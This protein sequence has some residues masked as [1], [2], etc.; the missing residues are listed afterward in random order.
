MSGLREKLAGIL[1]QAYLF[2]DLDENETAMF[3][4]R[5]RFEN[6]GDGRTVIAEGEEGQTLFLI[7]SGDVKVTK[8]IE[9]EAEQVIGILRPGDFFGEMALLDRLPRSATVKAMGQV[10]LA[11][12]DHDS[13]RELFEENPSI[14][15]RVV[16]TFAEVLSMR[17]RD[18][19]DRMRA[20]LVLERSF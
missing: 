18:T 9:Q 15:Y 19:N 16:K 13:I 10:E 6:Y 11:L 5:A 12:L 1:R 8:S 3:A 14:G 20:L 2:R 7:L 17:L 4:S